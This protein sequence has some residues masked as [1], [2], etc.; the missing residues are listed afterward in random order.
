ML[1]LLDRDPTGSA[2]QAQLIGDP[3]ALIVRCTDLAAF[4][5]SRS[6]HVRLSIT[7]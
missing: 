7:S 6:G 2:M 1:K 4:E 3:V 5:L